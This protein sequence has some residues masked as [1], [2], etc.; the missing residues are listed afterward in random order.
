MSA[1]F[2]T[3]K[4]PRHLVIQPEVP[5]LRRKRRWHFSRLL[6]ILTL[7]LVATWALVQLA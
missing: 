6:L 5:V 3:R 4:V 1:I 7:L 2:K